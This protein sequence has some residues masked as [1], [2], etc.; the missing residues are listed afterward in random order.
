MAIT[1][2]GT[3]G[4]TAPGM[5]STPVGQT[6]AA[7]GKFTSLAAESLKPHITSGTATALTTSSGISGAYNDGEALA[8]VAATTTGASPTLND[9]A[10]GAKALKYINGAGV[11][12]AIPVG[13]LMAGCVATV[14]YSSVSNAFIVVSRDRAAVAFQAHLST[15]QTVSSTVP[16][17]VNID[18][19]DFDT[20][21]WFDTVNHRFLPLVAGWYLITGQ[22]YVAGTSISRLL[23]S[24]WKNGAY[25]FIGDD[26][27]GGSSAVT[28]RV[29]A[30]GMTY[31]NGST[32]Y[33][34]LYATAF[35]TGTIQVQPNAAGD[36]RFSAQL[37]Y[38][39]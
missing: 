12:T 22:A 9:G 38:G 32:D 26:I 30:T 16:T 13:Y 20:H 31:L 7:A 11:A 8:I 39:T 29:L 36:G 4:I 18:T 1:L 3:A 33:V 28:E 27:T 2:D 37:V 17:K 15:A 19:S 25:S 24:V 21:G 35:G 6:A 5:N 10:R 34:E 14:V 23:L